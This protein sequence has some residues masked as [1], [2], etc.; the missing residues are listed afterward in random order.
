MRQ[1]VGVHG[2]DGG[3]RPVLH[4]VVERRQDALFELWARVSGGHRGQRLGS[5]LLAPDADHVDFHAGLQQGDFGCQELGHAGGG[6]QGDAEPHLVG[7]GFVDA[8]VAA[9]SPGPRR[10]RRP[11]SGRWSRGSARSG[12]GRETSPRRRA[13]PTSGCSPRRRPC[14][15]PKKNTRREWLKSNSSSVSRMNSVASRASAVSGTW[16]PAMV[17]IE[18]VVMFSSPSLVT[19]AMS[20][21]RR[22]QSDPGR[23]G[24]PLHR[25]RHNG[26][27]GCSQSAFAGGGDRR[28]RRGDA[29]RRRGSG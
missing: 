6:V 21:R 22:G 15:A 10:R 26:L 19:V 25:K 4:A 23:S 7:F 27:R 20:V 8:V 1:H 17:S 28:L 18:L 24:R 16:M 29:V 12:R 5:Q 2:A 9:R 13:A 14:S 3:L 11:R